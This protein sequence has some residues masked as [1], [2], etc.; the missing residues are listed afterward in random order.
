MEIK[1]TTQQ[2]TIDT[3][4]ISTTP[5][6]NSKVLVGLLHRWHDDAAD[7][8]NAAK[9]AKAAKTVNMYCGCIVHY[10]LDAPQVNKLPL[11]TI[12]TPT[13]KRCAIMLNNDCKTVPPFPQYSP[14]DQPWPGMD[15]KIYPDMLSMRATKPSIG[16]HVCLDQ[17]EQHRTEVFFF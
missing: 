10:I 6:E 5:L 15:V 7:A 17:M 9:A 8:S 1:H 11:P 4:V 3:H 14:R 12:Q 13:I 16:L 2:V